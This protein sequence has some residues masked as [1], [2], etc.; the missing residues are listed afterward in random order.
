MRRAITGYDMIHA[1]AIGSF[2]LM[3]RF[4]SARFTTI[5][6]AES[7][8]VSVGYITAAI[9]SADTQF[10]AKTRRRCA[11]AAEKIGGE[12]SENVDEVGRRCRRGRIAEW[13]DAR[14]RSTSPVVTA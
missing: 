11:R 7:V 13:K 10:P 5:G 14:S 6:R 4:S 1:I 12:I 2:E 3:R 9:K 8:F